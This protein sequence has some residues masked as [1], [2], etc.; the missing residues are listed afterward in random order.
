LARLGG[1]QGGERG[2]GRGLVS[3]PPKPPPMRALHDDVITGTWSRCATMCCH[4]GGC[5]VEDMTNIEPSSPCSAQAACIFEDKMFLAFERK[6]A[7]EDFRRFR[8]C[9]LNITRRMKL[10]SV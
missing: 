7:F 5:C 9:V 4:F 1:G 3:L 6:F 8:E 10:G 2:E